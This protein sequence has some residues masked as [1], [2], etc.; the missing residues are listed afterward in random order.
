V[1]S[2]HVGAAFWMLYWIHTGD[3]RATLCAVCCVVVAPVGRK[4]PSN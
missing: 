1:S 2:F 4:E 3:F